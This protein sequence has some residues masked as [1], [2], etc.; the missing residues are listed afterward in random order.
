MIILPR[1]LLLEILSFHHQITVS[2]QLN[3][4]RYALPVQS[5]TNLIEAKDEKS[6][7]NIEFKAR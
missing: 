7:Q 4:E 1:E 2:L 5:Q 3:R 6:G